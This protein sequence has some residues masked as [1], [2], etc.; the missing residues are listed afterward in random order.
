MRCGCG[1]GTGVVV[2]ILEELRAGWDADY[3]MGRGGTG[4]NEYVGGNRKGREK[5]SVYP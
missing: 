2:S 4:K 3:R 1:K 5:K